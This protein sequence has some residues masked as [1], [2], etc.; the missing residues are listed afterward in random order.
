MT[1]QEMAHVLWMLQLLTDRGYDLHA[2]A[3][4]ADPLPLGEYDRRYN[5]KAA[6]T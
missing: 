4:T 6:T 5:S 1:D 3:H 2:L